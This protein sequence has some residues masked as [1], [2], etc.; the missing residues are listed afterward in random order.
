MLR[1][2]S[3]QRTKRSFVH[4]DRLDKWFFLPWLS[5][6]CAP[7]LR[8]LSGGLNDGACQDYQQPGARVSIE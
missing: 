8:G 3:F 6:L 7:L 5:G 4:F 2:L 1:R